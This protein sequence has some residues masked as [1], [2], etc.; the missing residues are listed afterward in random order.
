MTRPLWRIWT[1]LLHGI[2]KTQ[3]ISPNPVT[4]E[5]FPQH[6]P[7]GT[8]SVVPP[9]LYTTVQRSFEAWSPSSFAVVLVCPPAPVCYQAAQSFLKKLCIFWTTGYTATHSFSRH[10][11]V[12]STPVASRTPSQ[13]HSC[14]HKPSRRR[15]A[16]DVGS[17]WRVNEYSDGT[18]GGLAPVY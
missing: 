15:R 2:R 13:G 8:V 10:C 18:G 4:S 6:P 17:L 12:L 5:S 9:L 1:I 16:L 7:E 3:I 14:A 11:C